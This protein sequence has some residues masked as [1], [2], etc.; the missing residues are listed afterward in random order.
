VKK[1]AAIIVSAT[2]VWLPTSAGHVSQ[3]GADQSVCCCCECGRAN[4]C[5]APA[6]PGPPAAPAMPATA[7]QFSQL[8]LA[9]PT[10]VSWTL[11]EFSTPDISTSPASLLPADAAPLFARHCAR[12]I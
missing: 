2:L 1:L 3:V 9:A 12:L 8:C 7:A 4:C 5:V 11:P 6:E 10:A